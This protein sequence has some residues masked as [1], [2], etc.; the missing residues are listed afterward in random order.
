MVEVLGLL[1]LKGGRGVEIV[2]IAGEDMPQP[3]RDLLV[4]ER[5]M[6]RTLE[7]FFG[8]GVH[9]KQ[10]EVVRDSDVL[11]RRVL[12]VTDDAETVVEYGAIRIWLERFDVACKAEILE[13]WTP[14]GTILGDEAFAYICRPGMYF[15]LRGTAGLPDALAVD[16]DAVLY[17][18]AN[19]I[20]DAEGRKL[21]EVV[22]ILPVLSR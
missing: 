10:L 19:T 22:E 7:G 14:L 3:Y 17:G 20:S 4:H 21:A 13:A 11:Q 1:G 2:E 15:R 6:T 16:G 9:L 5:A 12:L 8:D 18:R